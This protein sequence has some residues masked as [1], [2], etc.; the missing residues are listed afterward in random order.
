MRRKFPTEFRDIIQKAE[1]MGVMVPSGSLVLLVLVRRL[2]EIVGVPD[3]R[4]RP[5]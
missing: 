1:I 5:W 3:S 2:L 4:I